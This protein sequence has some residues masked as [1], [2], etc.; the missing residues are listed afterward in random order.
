M[1]HGQ[2]KASAHGVHYTDDGFKIEE[3]FRQCC[4]C[5]CVWVYKPGS[6]IRRGYCHKH[7]GWLCGQDACIAEQVR[8]IKEYEEVTGKVVSCLAHEEKN[9]FLANQL[10]KIVGKSD[11]TFTTTPSG[12]IIPV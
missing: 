4:H 2:N 11:K 9:D 3:E 6:G 5:Q 7:D 8:L 10:E 1:I 12:L